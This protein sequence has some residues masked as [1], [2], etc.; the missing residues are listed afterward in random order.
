MLWKEF[1][2]S[3]DCDC[4]VCPLKEKD[5]CNGASVSCYGDEPVY[6][7]CCEFEDDLDLDEYIKR[8]LDNIR[9][10]ED[11]EYK[12]IN[13]ARVK[14]EKA[15]K[16]AETRRQL[17]MYCID[18]ITK[19]KSL[20]N[21]IKVIQKSYDSYKTR[22]SA[23]NSANKIFGY[24]ARFEETV[25]DIERRLTTLQEQLVIAEQNYVNKRKEFY[26]NRKIQQ[27]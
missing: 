13:A 22:V 25:P 24:S 3:T 14:K 15:Q 27:R 1:V 20:K 18:E 21:A 7:P 19:I 23:M 12:R 6:A 5:L 17:R 9:K 26:T 4:D 11:W 16:A 8:S 2:D 10:Y